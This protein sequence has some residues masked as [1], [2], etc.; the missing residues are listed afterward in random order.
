L[1]EAL[2]PSLVEVSWPYRLLDAPALTLALFLGALSFGMAILRSHLWDIDRIINR[3]LVYSTLTATLALI[4]LGL[5]IGLQ[6]LLSEL[7]HL[8]SD[9]ASVA[10][11]LVIADLFQPLKTYPD[12]HRPPLLSPQV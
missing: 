6:F 2:L 4:Y 3:T 7:M 11:T 9:I 10:S 12:N 1:P 5:V 8:S